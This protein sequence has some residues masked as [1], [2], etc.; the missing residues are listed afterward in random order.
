MASA[1]FVSK[2]F[3]KS[4]VVL[5]EAGKE[6]GGW[7]KSRRV[8]VE[9]GKDVLFELGPRTLR[10]ATVTASLVSLWNLFRI[11]RCR[12]DRWWRGV[13]LTRKL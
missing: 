8:E 1:Y 5:F 2:E 3:P 12:T 6:T 7:I 4:R 9:D 11:E 13:G 10:N